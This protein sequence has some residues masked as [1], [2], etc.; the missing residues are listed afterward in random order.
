MS[1]VACSALW[2]GKTWRA[3]AERWI[4]VVLRERGIAVT[5]EIDQPRIRPWSTL[6]TVSTDA[7]LVWFKEN[8]PGQAFEAP[9]L[10]VLGDVVPD[11]VVAPLAVDP[12][13]GWLLTTD[14]GTTLADRA[15]EENLWVD[16]VSQWA[17][18][19]RRLVP[20]LERVVG[21]GLTVMRATAAGDYLASRVAAH[22]VLPSDDPAHLA[23]DEAERLR[24][25]APV[26][27]EWG[28]RLE[29]GPV[30]TTLDHNDL[31]LNNTFALRPGET[32]L[33]YFDL[34]DAVVGHPFGS[35][36]V[37]LNVL[38]HALTAGPDDPRLRRVVEAYLEPWTDLAPARD[39]RALVE[40][41]LALGRLNR[42][43]SWRRIAT[44]VSDEER[45]EYG[46]L[47]PRW[48]TALLEPLP[49]F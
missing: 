29:A 23:A 20:H 34:G 21:A 44:T 47:Q 12:E 1:E 2:A 15:G 37:P 9:L 10:A 19:Q 49:V 26:V 7:G 16:V 27:A 18:V 11:A 24:A 13:R 42:H 25:L 36:L 14:N 41:A 17:D 8:C 33:R 40:P 30:P 32:R 39:L 46:H 6:L 28:A 3:E 35:L 22:A 45:A 43:E 4:R 48:L 5:G 31:H 38:A